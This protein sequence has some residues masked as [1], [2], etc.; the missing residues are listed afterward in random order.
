MWPGK[1]LVRERIQRL[2]DPGSPF[3]E[4]SQLAGHQLY[5]AEEVPAAGIITGVGRISGSVSGRPRL[6][7]TDH[8]VRQRTAVTGCPRPHSTGHRVRQHTADSTR[9]AP[10]VHDH[11]PPATASDS[12]RHL[13]YTLLESLWDQGWE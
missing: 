11:T 13:R 8:R 9:Q 7:P 4:L 1:L 3:L 2:L 12:T 5:G 6:H 10:A